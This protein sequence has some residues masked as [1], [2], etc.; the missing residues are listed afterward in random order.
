MCRDPVTWREQLQEPGR[1]VTVVTNLRAIPRGTTTVDVLFPGVPPLRDIRVSLAS[2]GA[3]RSG[4]TARGPRQTWTYRSNRTQPGWRLHNWP[5]PA[6][7]ITEGDFAAT[8]DP[9]LG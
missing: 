7:N 9:I 4:G 5:T 6:P 8:V 1:R 2:D 3:L